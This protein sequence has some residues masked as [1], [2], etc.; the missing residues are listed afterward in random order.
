MKSAT[1]TQKLEH[2][3]ALNQRAKVERLIAP[4]LSLELRSTAELSCGENATFMFLLFGATA[5]TKFAAFFFATCDELFLLTLDAH[6]LLGL[7]GRLQRLAGVDDGFSTK[8]KKVSSGKEKK[9]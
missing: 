1:A 7:V 2:S 3:L 6:L 4:S 5:A 8:I 9:S